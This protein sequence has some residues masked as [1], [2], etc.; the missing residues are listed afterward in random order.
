[1]SANVLCGNALLSQND[2]DAWWQDE[3]GDLFEG[4]ADL[5]FRLNP[6][7]WQSR[8]RGFGDVLTRRGEGLDGFDAVI[9]NPPYIR[10]QEL[11][12]WAAEESEF[13]KWRYE[14]AAR[15]NYDIYVCF[16]EKGLSLLNGR[17]LL[18]YICPHKFWQADYGD[19]LRAII[20]EGGHL[21]SLIDFADQQVFQNATTYTAIHVLGKADAGE[22]VDYAKVFD[23]NDGESQVAQVV[24]SKGA[25]GTARFTAD[26]PPARGHWNFL[27][28]STRQLLD[29][30][31]HDNAALYP[32]VCNAVFQGII[33]GAD[34]IFLTDA[35]GP[36]TDGLV[37]F[38]SE[39]AGGAVKVEASLLVPVV[40]RQ[41]FTPYDAR[42]THHL[43]LPYNR[44]NGG[45]IPEA[46]MREQYP[47]AWAHI[48]RFQERLEARERR[49]FASRWWGFSGA[50]NIERWC[51]P[52]V[53]LPYMINRL[54][55]APGKAGVFFVNVTTGGY[56]LSPRPGDFEPMPDYL[57]G[58][59]N[60]RLLDFCLRNLSNHF[61]GGYFPANKQY[62]RRLPIKLPGD[63]GER[64]LAGEVARR[65]RRGGGVEG[66]AA[67]GGGGG[68][69]AAGSGG[70][71]RGRRAGDRRAG[72]A[73]LRRRRR[74][75]VAFPRRP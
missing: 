1:M 51:R 42:P 40:R 62:V 74:R 44:D 73:P 71:G 72:P 68:P 10:V 31:L 69:R 28:K 36:E 66:G 48:E 63:A 50:K 6:F 20:A 11:K 35:L 52:K 8:T 46:T 27:P 3:R 43:L 54:M 38:A 39:A 67:A 29:R 9:G 70:V 49:K 47:Q 22:G 5:R 30:L 56:G 75:R 12:K 13:Y 33:T 18:G 32:D 25:A 2:F 58:L 65:A 17:G 61:H 16:I 64:K 7:D 4:D 53:L 60:S 15:G 41:G 26:A 45:I 24:A 21:R 37:S 59:L 14:S 55:A 57:V 34:D 23:L 19:A